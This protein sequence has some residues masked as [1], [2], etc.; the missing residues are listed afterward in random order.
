[1]VHAFGSRLN[2]T[3]LRLALPPG[4]LQQVQAEE[5]KLAGLPVPADLDPGTRAAIQESIREAFVFGF[6]T[7]ML[8]CA[9][10]SLAS[11]LVAWLMIPKSQSASD[12][13]NRS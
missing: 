2:H 1:M 5:I 9:A 3:L 12:T 13:K 11:A 4:I 10:L 8:I 7:I 6:R